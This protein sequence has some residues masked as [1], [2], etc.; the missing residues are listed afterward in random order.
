[1]I[2]PFKLNL[3]LFINI[4]LFEVKVYIEDRGILYGGYV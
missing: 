3:N 2:S 1:M 4:S